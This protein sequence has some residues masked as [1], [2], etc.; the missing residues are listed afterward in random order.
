MQELQHDRVSIE[1][2]SFPLS[3]KK[4]I[5][6]KILRLD[7]LHPVVS[8][9]KWYKLQYHL[10]EALHQHKKRI[11]TWGGA[12]S[13]HIVAT[14]A[15]S[16]LAGLQSLGIIRGEKPSSLSNTLQESEKMG[17]QFIFL[18]RE[19][20][21]LRKIPQ[22]LLTKDDWEIPEGGY[23]PLGAQGASTITTLFK[24][25]D[26]THILCAVGTGT[27]LAGI[28][29][30]LPTST[31]VIGI[32][33]LK[34]SDAL[35]QA[36]KQLLLRPQENW[37]MI[38][39]YEWGGYAKH[40]QGLLDFMNQWYLTHKIPTDIVYTGKECFA[41][42]ELIEKNYFPENSKLLLIHSGGLQGNRS[43]AANTLLF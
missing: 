26:F 18:T 7:Q 17:M 36:V 22:G 33:V 41:V 20:Y 28:I 34:G 19:N 24:P 2:V 43:L 21:Q 3:D 39:G 12:W 38:P 5:S 9:N 42:H 27:M 37:S 4:N 16:Q 40:P 23:S 29:N 31:Q 11:V 15:A 14:A 10:Q 6:L 8:G 1:E 35:T 32:P 25:Q 30:A 13:N